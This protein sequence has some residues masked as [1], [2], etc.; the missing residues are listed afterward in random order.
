MKKTYKIKNPKPIK[1]WA[2]IDLQKVYTRFTYDK[3]PPVLAIYDKR[4]HI[5]K[6]WKFARKVIRV[7]VKPA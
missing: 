6:E 3:K 1:A 7:W 4:P 2:I 5:T